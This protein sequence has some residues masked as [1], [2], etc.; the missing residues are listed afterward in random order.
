MHVSGKNKIMGNCSFIVIV[1]E[2]SV[3]EM[4][5]GEMRGG[6]DVVPTKFMV[7]LGLFKSMKYNF[8]QYVIWSICEDVS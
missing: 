7:R 3:G 4:K 6:N 8:S 5:V 1:G 2:M